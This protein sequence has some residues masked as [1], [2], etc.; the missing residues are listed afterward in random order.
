LLDC[1]SKNPLALFGE[2]KGFYHNRKMNRYLYFFSIFI[3]LFNEY[4]TIKVFAFYCVSR[5][6]KNIPHFIVRKS[7]K[8]I[9]SNRVIV[10]LPFFVIKRYNNRVCIKSNEWVNTFIHSTIIGRTL[11]YYS[12]STFCGCLLK[13]IG[14]IK[15]YFNLSRST[16]FYNILSF[17]PFIMHIT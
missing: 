2:T 14:C 13:N 1:I 6:I 10:N 12:L 7:F 9:F 3:I 17:D 4:I 8:L 15:I 5:L 11:N 16:V